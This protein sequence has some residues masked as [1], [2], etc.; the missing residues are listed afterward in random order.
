[1]NKKTVVLLDIDY[2]LFDTKTFKDSGLTNYSLYSEVLGVLKKLK[3]TA[4]LGI[5]SKG[6]TE[7]QNT[8][9]KQTGIKDFFNQD[10]VHVFED[11]DVNINNVLEKYK[12]YRIFLVDD[13]L[14]VLYGAKTYNP[15]IFSIWVKRGPFAEKQEALEGFL[16]D[17]TIENLSSLDKIILQSR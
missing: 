1:M 6:E 2:T 15:A 13:K 17:A 10:N 9:L 5:F 3:G 8:K 12:D 16:P 14:P 4:I 7:F 11:K